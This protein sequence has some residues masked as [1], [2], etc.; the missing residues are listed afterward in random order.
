MGR[1][2]PAWMSV[3]IRPMAA[4]PKNLNKLLALQIGP[5]S[6]SRNEINHNLYIG[7]YCMPLT[8][9]IIV[10]NSYN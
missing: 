5:A 6:I 7:E 2:F 4:Q 8:A 9:K 1:T 10:H 3:S